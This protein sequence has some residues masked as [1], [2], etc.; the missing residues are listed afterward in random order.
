MTK[1]IISATASN[2]PVMLRAEDHASA[3]AGFLAEQ[4]DKAVRLRLATEADA[5]FLLDLRLDPTRNQNI[6]ATSANLRDQI[7]WM[8]D[9]QARHDAGQEAYFVIEANKSPQGS[10]RFYDYDSSTNSYCWGSWII[11]PGAVPA[12]AF[13]SILLAYDLAFGPL[14]FSQA[15]F[16]VRQAGISVW[17]FH[18]K[19]GAIL[20]SA[21]ELDRHYVYSDKNYPQAR[22]WLQT[23]ALLGKP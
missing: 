15:R 5:A 6:S 16:D 19:M 3:I 1:P 22:R 7:Q 20:S 14:R 4:S 12:T 23:F 13:H 8:R 11:R 18:E 9:Y 21:D 2:S 10:L 17:K